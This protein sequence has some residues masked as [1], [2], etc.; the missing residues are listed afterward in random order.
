MKR[1]IPSVPQLYRNVRRWT[2]IVRIM[3]KYGLADWLSRFQIDFLTDL[4]RTSAD[5]AQSQLTQHQRI[6]L[7]LS[8]L[9]PTFIKFGQLLSTR[10]DLIGSDLADELSNLQSDTPSDSFDVVKSIIEKEQGRPL[11]EVFE[12]FDPVPIASASIGQVH[13]AKIRLDEHDQVVRL[14]GRPARNTTLADVVVKVRHASIESIIETDLDILAGLSQLADRLEDFK[15]YQPSLIVKEMSRSMRRELEFERETGNLKQFRILFENDS[16]IVIPKPYPELCSA[17]MITMQRLEGVSLRD[18]AK[19]TPSQYDLPEIARQGANLYLQMI[20]THGFY[21]ADPHP[22]NI[23]ITASETIGMLDFGLVGRISEQLREDIEAMLVAIVNQDVSMLTALIK[24]VGNCPYDLNESALSNDIAD[25]VGQ[26]STQLVSH[27]DMSGALRDFVSVVRSYDITLPSE[28]SLLIKV[29]V[30]LEGTGRQLNPDFSLMEVMKPFQ[31]MLIL[32]RLSPARQL[33]KM[34]RFYLEV[35]QLFDSLPT[36]LSNI[37]DQVQSGRFDIHLD[38]RRLGP[39]ANRL[40]VGL[41]TSALF[42]GSALMLSFQVPPLLFP[43]D[44]DQSANFIVSAI[45]S[46]GIKDLSLL[47]LT[48]VIVSF[49]MGLRLM[50]AIR[51][52]GNLD[53]PD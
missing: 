48:G 16:R 23:L 17:R 18:A 21:H 34:R 45:Q 5:D 9:G 3:S 49:L 6:R 40:V 12:E 1:S 35:E 11:E 31:R 22:G 53:Q 8:E 28:A 50:W 29:L 52:S 4:L 25:F 2:E 7:A 36:K 30:T 43:S 47:G 20:F 38:H 24:R 19:Q 41:M 46:V 33:R 26:Y 42:L 15:N 51:K 27:F 44:T 13:R 37:L 32:K 10:P 39:T 14:N